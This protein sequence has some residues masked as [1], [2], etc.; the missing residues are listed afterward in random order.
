M[1]NNKK[2][3]PKKVTKYQKPDEEIQKEQKIAELC[4]V[5]KFSGAIK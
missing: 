2:P 4:K 5:L 3:E 1:E